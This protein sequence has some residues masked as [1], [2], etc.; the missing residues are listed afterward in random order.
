MGR[1]AARG[2]GL[3]ETRTEPSDLTS[4]LRATQ[5]PLRSQLEPTS[6]RRPLRRRR[7]ASELFHP[8]KLTPGRRQSAVRPARKPICNRLLAQLAA[9]TSAERII[10][11]INNRL[12]HAPAD[13]KSAALNSVSV[14][15]RPRAPLKLSAYLC[16]PAFMRV[17]G[18]RRVGLTVRK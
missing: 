17:V 18:I 5:R 12:R 10:F 1:A 16:W 14:R 2:M 4:T 7:L 8:N 9:H 13:S 3:L 6:N 11:L 15:L